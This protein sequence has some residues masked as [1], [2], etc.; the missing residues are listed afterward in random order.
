MSLRL[1]SSVPLAAYGTHGGIHRDAVHPQ[2]SRVSQ[3]EPPYTL[4]DIGC[5]DKV[6]INPKETRS[7]SDPQENSL[8]NGIFA[9]L[10]LSPVELQLTKEYVLPSIVPF[11]QSER[12]ILDP[13]PQAQIRECPT[14]IEREIMERPL[15]INEKR[16]DIPRSEQPIVEKQARK[17]MKIRRKKMKK[18][19]YR[20]WKKRNKFKLRAMFAKRRKKKQKLWEEH[21]EQN[22]FKGLTSEYTDWYLT[23]KK[24]EAAIFLKHLGIHVEEK[25]PESVEEREKQR[26]LK[27]KKTTVYRD[28]KGSMRVI[29]TPILPDGS[30]LKKAFEEDE[31]LAKEKRMNEANE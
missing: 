24:E 26:K 6:E 10:S 30:S 3:F 19:Q 2:K 14:Y 7:P 29:P 15:G 18:H 27:D 25:T 16:I 17:I 5:K 9:N 21:L 31:R 28:P 13:L 23:K 22:K 20:K 1:L 11:W 8:L 12:V 4:A